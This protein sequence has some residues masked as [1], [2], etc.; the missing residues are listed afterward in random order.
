[1]GRWSPSGSR[2]S[3]PAPL[4]A[5][6]RRRAWASSS[7]CCRGGRHRRG[8]LPLLALAFLGVQLAVG[9]A[10]GSERLYLSQSIAVSVVLGLAFAVSSSTSRPLAGVFAAEMYRLDV[11]VW[12]QPGYVRTFQL[13]SLVWA[14]YYLLYAA[15]RGAALTASVGGFAVLSAVLGLPVV[16]LLLAWS[17]R[18]A[19]RRLDN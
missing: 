13:V 9:L 14:A 12:R 3:L 7:S 11:A 18:F 8:W 4:R 6:R 16:V 15:V 10:S 2:G 17:V 1:M 5:W 19:T